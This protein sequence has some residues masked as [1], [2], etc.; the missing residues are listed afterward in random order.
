MAGVFTGLSETLEAAS[1]SRSSRLT[2]TFIVSTKRV[3]T[4]AFRRTFGLPLDPE[5]GDDAL[6][7]R[8][9]AL[10]RRYG[11]QVGSGKVPFS[12]KFSLDAD[13]PM[14]YVSA[15]LGAFLDKATEVEGPSELDQ[16]I[17]EEG[18]EFQ[19]ELRRVELERLKVE[20]LRAMAGK[21]GVPGAWR[22]KKGE[23]IEKIIAFEESAAPTAG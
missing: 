3:T 5:E 8:T 2:V 13:P 14:D 15:K 23:L 18:P 7:T 12:L 21:L 19:A 17:A 1:I 10:L 11:K 20:E 4:V 9:V 6:L 16:L 22:T